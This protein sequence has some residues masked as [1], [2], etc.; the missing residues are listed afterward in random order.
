MQCLDVH[1]DTSFRPICR[2]V[3][4][5]TNRSYCLTILAVKIFSEIAMLWKISSFRWRLDCTRHSRWS[6]EKRRQRTKVQKKKKNSKR[7]CQGHGPKKKKL[8]SGRE[9]CKSVPLF[10]G[11]S[12]HATQ[13]HAFFYENMALI[14]SFIITAQVF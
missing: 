9:P 5:L 11:V 2:W 8:A 7:G 13:K 3:F 14:K 1:T 6:Y 12:V 4:R 10:Y